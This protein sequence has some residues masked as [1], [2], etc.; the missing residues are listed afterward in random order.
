MA[1]AGVLSLAAL[2][3]YTH[4]LPDLGVELASTMS[5]FQGL[6][7]HRLPSL[8]LRPAG[9][10][11]FGWV[12]AWVQVLGGV[13]LLFG[14]RRPQCPSCPRRTHTERAEMYEVSC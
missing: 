6:D 5:E 10:L 13:A 7:V 11:Y 14:F 9:S 4:H 8:T 3:V 2:G 12:G 1:L